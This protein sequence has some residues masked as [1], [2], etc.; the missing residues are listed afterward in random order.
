MIKRVI[1]ILKVLIV[2]FI[3]TGLMTLLSA[4]I[5][6]KFNLDERFMNAMAF[7]IYGVSNLV[8]GFVYC[9]IKKNKRVIRGL[10]V[11]LTYFVI[12]VL[13]SVIS[14]TKD[15]S[16]AGKVTFSGIACV[17]SGILGGI[18]S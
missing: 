3:L 1:D 5:A 12:L 17:V 10:A 14:G 15:F 13:V 7:L 9:K 8:A 18:L 2:A 16:N 6:Y 11:G 4:Y